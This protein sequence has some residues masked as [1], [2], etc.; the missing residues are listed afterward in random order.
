MKQGLSVPPFTDPAVLIEAARSAEASGWDGFFL[1]D[2]LRW[3]RPVP[4][5]DPWTLLGAIALVTDRMTIGTMVTPLTRRRPWVVARHLMTLD[6]L[7]GG[8][9]VLG[10]GLG[11]PDAEDFAGFGE[12]VD[13]RE[14]G[15]LLDESLEVLAGALAGP[16]EHAGDHYRLR[17]DL[18][19]SPVQR[20]RPRIWVG[21]ILPNRRPLERALRWD[22]YVPIGGGE[23]VTP[24]R[25]A[26]A[27]GEREHP[28]CWDLVVQGAPGVPADEYAALGV[29]WLI[30]ELS[31]TDDL[32]ETV[33]RVSTRGPGVAP[34]EVG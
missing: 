16:L 29:T 2:H 23:A 24:D 33:A 13:P 3:R 34:G 18:R 17:D 32:A 7:T 20:P 26:A 6:H 28:P 25:L 19:P 5:H 21:G 8:R 1:W 22:G 9:V 4:V 11:A 14:R 15:R 12:V 31:V 10:V 30:R 27:L